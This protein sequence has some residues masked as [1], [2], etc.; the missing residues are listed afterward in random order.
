MAHPLSQSDGPPGWLARHDSIAWR[1]IV[2]V[3]LAIVVAV[4]VIWM[5]V[6]RIVNSMAV[7]DAVLADQ[8]V[9]AEFKT[10]R[11]YYT[12][13]IVNKVVQGGAFQADVDH[14]ENAKVIPLPAT[15][16][17]DLGMSSR[18]MRRASRCSANTRFRAARIGSS[19]TF[20][21]RPGPI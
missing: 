1:L 14:K 5:T 19:T 10:I 7:T 3:P 9:A 12:E 8:Q 20:S 6:P 21:S 11:A 15:F 4:V 2:P 18:T 13:N 17:H 16:L